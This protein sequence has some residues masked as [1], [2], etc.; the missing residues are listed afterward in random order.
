MLD[1]PLCSERINNISYILTNATFLSFS[2]N[3]YTYV[4]KYVCILE[5]RSVNEVVD[6]FLG[7]Y[8][9]HFENI[10]HSFVTLGIFFVRK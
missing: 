5:I 7:N 10:C 2:I 4:I 6:V 1:T 3:I 9:G 8:K